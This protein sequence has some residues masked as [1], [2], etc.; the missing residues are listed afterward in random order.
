MLRPHMCAEVHA[1]GIEPAEERRTRPHLTLH[2]IDCRRRRFIVDGFHA[3]PGERAGV[4]D[5]LSADPA[6]AWLLGGVIPIRC[7]ATQHAPWAKSFP[8][9]RIARIE[10]VLRVLLRVKVIQIAVE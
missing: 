8:E 7:L 4:F 2:E 10:P 9:L 5:G 6:P 1:S 3:L